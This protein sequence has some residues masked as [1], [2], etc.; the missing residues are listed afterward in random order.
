[1]MMK[2]FLRVENFKLSV[3]MKKIFLKV[4]NLKASMMIEDFCSSG[5]FKG[6]DKDDMISCKWS[7]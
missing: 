6:M 4:D 1:M 5:E 7:I 2:V 3:L